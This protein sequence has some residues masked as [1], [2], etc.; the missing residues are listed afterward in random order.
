MDVLKT[1]LVFALIALCFAPFL[2]LINMFLGIE[3]VIICAVLLLLD[4]AMTFIIKNYFIK[5]R[6]SYLM[7][8]IAIGV[9]IY[10]SVITFT[11]ASIPIWVVLLI[12]LVLA[13]AF[14]V[15][16]LR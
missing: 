15:C 13:F 7:F 6:L 16:N 5:T 11:G 14:V 1:T 12:I 10:Y 2:A 8:A 9:I 3:P 4:F